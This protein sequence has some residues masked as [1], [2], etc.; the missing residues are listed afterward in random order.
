MEPTNLRTD[1]RKAVRRRP[2]PSLSPHDP[3]QIYSKF[4]AVSPTFYNL[5]LPH[6][7]L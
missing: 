4:R 7:Y 5:S 2:P 1:T 3:I 6:A